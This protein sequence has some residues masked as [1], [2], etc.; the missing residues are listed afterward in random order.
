M[1]VVGL[2]SRR[3]CKP[4]FVCKIFFRNV[5]ASGVV[6]QISVIIGPC[7]GGAVYSPAIDFV[8]MVDKTAP[9]HHR[10]RSYQDG[11][12]RRSLFRRFRRSIYSH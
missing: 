1:T 3:R 7:A 12:K 6:P 5:R 4:W 2:V 10:S 11:Y 8:I 9:V